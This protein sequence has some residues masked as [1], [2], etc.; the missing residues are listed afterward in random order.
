MKE[1]WVATA[2]DGASMLPATTVP[3]PRSY[4]CFPRKVGR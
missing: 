4:G 3:H 1:D 2:S